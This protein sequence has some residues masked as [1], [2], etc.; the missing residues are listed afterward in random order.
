MTAP[1]LGSSPATT[2][3][4]LEDVA[5]GD[6]P[7]AP[8]T[9]ST[10]R[11]R[12]L[13]ARLP[14]PSPC[15]GTDLL[16]RT[17]GSGYRH[18][19]SLARRADGQVIQLT[20]LLYAVLEAIDGERGFEAIAARVS[21]RTGR[22]VRA[23]DAVYL[24]AAKLIPLGLVRA[25]DGSEPELP[26]ANP[27]LAL[28]CKFV[29]S[30]PHLT[31]RI[32][33]PFAALFRPSLVLLFL[34]AF[35]WTCHFVIVER[36]LASSLHQAF[37]E[38][39]LLLAVFALTLV[40]A[41]FHEFGHAAA[42]RYGGATP[43]AMGVG[44]YLVWPAFYT[45]VTDS[46]RLGRG[47]RLRV[48]LG[49]LYFNAVFA[50]AT[51]VAWSWLR[52]DALLLLVVAQLLQ[53]S[54]QLA[55]LVRFDGYHILADLIGVPDLFAH[56]KP[57]L[58]GLLPTRWR[59]GQHQ[60]L[61]P[62]ARAAVTLWVVVVV[63][64]L[65]ALLVTIV[66]LVPRLAATAW[67]AL[68]VQ[69]EVL[70]TNW[71]D[72]EFANVGVRLL[73]IVSLV[74]PVATVTYLLA[75]VARRTAVRLWQ[76]S[77]GSRWR[78]AGVLVLG[79]AAVAGLSWLWWPGD[80]YRP[81]EADEGGPLPRLVAPEVL[82]AG[83]PATAAPPVAAPAPPNGGAVLPGPPPANAIGEPQ[84]GLILVPR[85]EEAG[86]AGADVVPEPTVIVLTDDGGDTPT[87]HE[88]D[89]IDPSDAVE[90]WPFPWGQ[91]LPTR[92]GDNRAIVVNTED[93]TTVYDVALAFVWVTDGGPVDERNE[94]FA[95]ASCRDCTS[96]AVAFQ[97]VMI[98]GQADVIIPV[99]TAVAANYDCESCRT[100][101]LAV[102]LVVTLKED[103][104]DEV[105]GQL[106]AVWADLE[107][108]ESEAGSLTLEEIYAWVKRAEAEILT[109]LIDAGAEEVTSSTTE[110]EEGGP[111]EE[112]APATD[113]P[114]DPDVVDGALAEPEPE[115]TAPAI[116]APEGYHDDT[117]T[118]DGTPSEPTGSGEP[119]DTDEP[120]GSTE[121]SEEPEPEPTT[122][123]TTE[124]ATEPDPPP[125]E[126][127]PEEGT[128]SDP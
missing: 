52:A 9:M 107:R 44:L 89:P 38:P 73:S 48:D 98:V 42:C 30:D 27:L 120:T 123:D 75:R 115:P 76:L 80:Q 8:D 6:G 106:A 100:H 65:A 2:T 117:P 82:P 18:P 37:Y 79:V 32:T 15:A 1:P 24:T 10:D 112:T 67:D 16:G 17:R 92:E 68:G 7:G 94:A 3:T 93:G 114:A 126:T 122:T 84:L 109:I 21:E 23:T 26:T 81:I 28:R 85:V 58:L 86:A 71:A 4:S 56:I 72:R 74:L 64:L 95:Y 59:G 25:P 51:L 50:V 125:E 49:G 118:S 108:L 119:T 41:A 97:V 124:P 99:N 36:G 101:A 90:E 22:T 128:T 47:G 69:W 127:D 13:V 31:R 35:V 12:E 110:D 11:R 87:V 104:D 33:R 40:S 96:V 54:R 116:D 20:P 45:D 111:L 63:P 91:P 83:V 14:A 55:P 19:P 62:W 78:R 61:K 103:P 46:Y 39:H 121:P 105:L 113:P 60:A 66:L 77:A 5:P 102:Q 88:T 57:T 34:A 29:V 53:M 70:V 43:G